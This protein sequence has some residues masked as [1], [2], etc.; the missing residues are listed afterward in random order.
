[1]KDAER[2]EGNPSGSRLAAAST[3]H[4]AS[5]SPGPLGASSSIESASVSEVG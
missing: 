5:S 1:M 3:W 4:G 2:E